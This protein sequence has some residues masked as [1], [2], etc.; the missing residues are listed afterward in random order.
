MT[1]NYRAIILSASYAMGNGW[2]SVNSELVNTLAIIWA[3]N[4]RGLEDVVKN[5]SDTSKDVPPL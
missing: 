3:K 2:R 4:E 1:I 5:G